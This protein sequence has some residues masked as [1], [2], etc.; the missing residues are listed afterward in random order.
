MNDDAQ[1]SFKAIFDLVKWEVSYLFKVFDLFIP[2]QTMHAPTAYTQ[3]VQVVRSDKDPVLCLASK[4]LLFIVEMVSWSGTNI[5]PLQNSVLNLMIQIQQINPPRQSLFDLTKATAILHTIS[6][7]PESIQ[8]LLAVPILPFA[9]G[10]P[11]LQ[12][13]NEQLQNQQIIAH[14]SALKDK[15]KTKIH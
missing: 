5:L 3:P 13:V 8:H 2:R 9:S 15:F 4:T 10:P 7:A 1:Q 6:D 11:T 12:N 14:F